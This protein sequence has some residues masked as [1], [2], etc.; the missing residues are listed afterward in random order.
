MGRKKEVTDTLDYMSQQLGHL[1]IVK[2]IPSDIDK[3]DRD[4]LANRA[5]D[6]RSACLLYLAVQLRHDATWLGTVGMSLLNAFVGFNSTLQGKLSRRF[7][8]VKEKSRMLIPV[9]KS[10]STIIVK[11]RKA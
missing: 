11:L 2:S 1:K 7:L 5:M 6:V 3:E 4:R 8:A 10:L 9:C